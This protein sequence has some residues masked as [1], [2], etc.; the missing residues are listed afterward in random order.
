MAGDL[1]NLV[2][3]LL[4]VNC[5][6]IGDAAKAGM[7]IGASQVFSRNFFP[8]G[9]LNQWWAGQENGSISFHNNRLVGHSRDIGSAGSAGTENSGDL[10]NPF[11]GHPRDVIKDPAEMLAIRKDV[12]L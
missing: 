11:A 12:G 4:F 1:A 6:M 3:S 7:H 5:K 10:G 8:G 2:K 9:G